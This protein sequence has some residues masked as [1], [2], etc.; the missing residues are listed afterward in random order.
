M[1]EELKSAIQAMADEKRW[2]F[3]YMAYVLLQQA[4]KERTRKRRGAAKD[5][6]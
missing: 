3:S 5:N 4:V 2:A 6:S 1:D